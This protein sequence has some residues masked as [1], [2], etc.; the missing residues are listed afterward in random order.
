MNRTRNAT[1]DGTVG[2]DIE[3]LI[4]YRGH[5][6]EVLCSTTGGGYCFSGGFDG[7]VRIWNIPKPSEELYACA[8][9]R[10]ERAPKP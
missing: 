9:T 1:K 10:Q 2:A 7:I 5:V 4:T 8:G 3:P 6:G